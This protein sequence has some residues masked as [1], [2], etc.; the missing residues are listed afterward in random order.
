MP[1][2]KVQP[3]GHGFIQKV[4][5]INR[6]ITKL[7]TLNDFYAH[8][9]KFSSLEFISLGQTFTELNLWEKTSW[10][11]K[12]LIVP[13]VDCIYNNYNAPILIEPYIKP[14]A[15]LK[16]SFS[17]DNSDDAIAAISQK[18]IGTGYDDY[19]VAKFYDALMDFCAK[20]HLCEDD[21]F[22]N[23]ANLGYHKQLG[24]RVL[25][26]GLTNNLLTNYY[27]LKGEV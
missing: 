25:D 1:S 2:R 17:F 16:E 12:H 18:L 5:L 7:T 13:I 6:K 11:E 22:Y 26:Y 15:S 3:Y 21:V 10:D 20:Y 19:Q 9:N 23:G 4:P 24:I 14:L 27:K 8:G